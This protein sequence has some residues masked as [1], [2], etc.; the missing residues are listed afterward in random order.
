MMFSFIFSFNYMRLTQ[1][2]YVIEYCGERSV[3]V[4]RHYPRLS[5]H[6]TLKRRTLVLRRCLKLKHKNQL[7]FKIFYIDTEKGVVNQLTSHKRDLRRQRG[8]QRP[9]IEPFESVVNKIAGLNG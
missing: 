9:G 6:I 8:H 2:L 7:L 4:E 1:T 5:P 3:P